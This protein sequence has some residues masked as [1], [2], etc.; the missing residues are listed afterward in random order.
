MY[1][2]LSVGSRAAICKLD[3]YWNGVNTAYFK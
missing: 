2:A 3:V 1:S